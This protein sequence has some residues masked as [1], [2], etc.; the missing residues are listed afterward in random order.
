VLSGPDPTPEPVATITEAAKPIVPPP[1]PVVAPPIDNPPTP[2]TT[3]VVTAPDPV[4]PTPNVTP[5]TTKSRPHVAAP[6]TTPAP[7]GKCPA[8]VTERL[9]NALKDPNKLGDRVELTVTVATDGT[10]TIKQ[11]GGPEA[12][13][14]A[15]RAKFDDVS[16]SRLVTDGKGALP[17]V[18]P[19]TWFP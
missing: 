15:A 6:S 3:P 1:A 7:P 4:T 8:A 9:G 12:G 10:K 13:L 19:L 18:T 2:P 14:A 5:A 16:E 11:R 17:C